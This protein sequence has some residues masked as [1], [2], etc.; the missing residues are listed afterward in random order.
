MKKIHMLETPSTTWEE[1]LAFKEKFGAGK[2]VI[3][4]TDASHSAPGYADVPGRRLFSRLQHQ[5]ILK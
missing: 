5:P 4:A 3:V 1:V 2:Q